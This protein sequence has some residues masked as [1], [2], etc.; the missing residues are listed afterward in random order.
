MILLLSYLLSSLTLTTQEYI[1]EQ[2]NLKQIPIEVAIRFIYKESHGV[3]W[4]T[5][6]EYNDSYSI[7]LTQL[8]SN[9]LD[10]FSKMFNNGEAFNP[11]NEKDNIRIGFAYLSYLKNRFGSWKLALLAYNAG[12][13]RVVEKRVPKSSYLYA[14]D[15]LG[16]KV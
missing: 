11:Y 16:G 15:I 10:Y 8:N 2:A 4:V 13:T 9:Y 3:S 1:V 14:K 5:R 7:G 6:K 12:P